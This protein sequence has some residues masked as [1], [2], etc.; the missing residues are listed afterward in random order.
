MR[1]PAI[2]VG[3]R[4]GVTI[5]A[6]ACWLAIS[7]AALAAQRGSGQPETDGLEVLQLRPGFY[8]IAGAGANIGVQ[9][10]PNGMVVVDAGSL[11]KAD[12]LVSA[13]KKLGAQPI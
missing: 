13:I 8:M 1:R 3:F 6:T 10:G 5:A 9:V 12:A 4:S 2:D 11:Q 7:L